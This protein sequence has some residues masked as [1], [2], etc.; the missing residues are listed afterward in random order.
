MTQT[1]Y[2]NFLSVYLL[3]SP[4]KE[5][6]RTKV[7]RSKCFTEIFT[8]LIRVLKRGCGFK[9]P[10]L[11][12]VSLCLTLTDPSAVKD[13]VSIELSFRHSCELILFK[14]ARKKW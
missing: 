4:G 6:F 8:G 14:N 1:F 10:Q 5:P 9:M 3:N 2:S 7:I 12:F 13:K 11:D